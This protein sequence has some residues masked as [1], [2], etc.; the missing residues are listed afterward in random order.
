M[1]DKNCDLVVHEGTAFEYNSTRIQHIVSD[2]EH[3]T[4]S[5][6][7]RR[8]M[9]TIVGIIV[10][11]VIGAI[12]GWVAGLITKSGRSFWMNALFGIIGSVIGGALMSVLPVGGGAVMTYVFDVIGA[13]LLTVIVN[14][15][16]K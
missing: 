10:M 3:G 13:V 16:F 12:I 7:E 2:V 9:N 8:A 4:I 15:L 14:A 11:I 1:F 5:Y 6:E